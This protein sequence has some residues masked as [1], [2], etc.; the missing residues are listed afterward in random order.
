MNKALKL[1]MLIAAVLV[2]LL[3]MTTL[4][5]D[6]IVKS[7]IEQQGS[8]LLKAQVEMDD[9]DISIFGGRG[10]IKGF[11][12]H[13]PKGFSDEEAVRFDQIYMEVN[14]WSLFADRVVVEEML[15][16]K[17]EF[18]FEQ[19]GTGINL[20]KLNQNI[21]SPSREESQKEVIIEYLRVEEGIV[22]LSTEIE[23]ERTTEIAMG[24]LEL[25]GIGK[26]DSNTLQQTVGQVMS[27]LLEKAVIEALKGGI[28]KQLEN[29]VRD[30]VSG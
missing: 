2:S 17:P 12:I 27:P 25:E 5:I 24:S 16:Q 1:S 9:L 22:K 30:L 4:S 18:F 15:I 7:A 6:G 8:K 13:N 26:E 29:K 11:V 23:K 20:R 28:L 3:F 14:L 10:E 21:G 19:Q